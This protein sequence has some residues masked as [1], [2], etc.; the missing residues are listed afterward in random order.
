MTAA[1]EPSGGAPNALD[2]R[3]CGIVPCYN[4]AGK[5]GGVVEGAL[6]H[7]PW[8]VVVD[9]CSTD[10][11]A[12]RAAAAGAS[13]LRHPVNRGKG[14]ALKSGFAEAGRLGYAAGLTLDGDG[15]HDTAEIPRFLAA[16][17]R[18][19]CDI[20][21]GC[22][23]LERAGMPWLRWRTNQFMSWVVSRKAGTKIRDSQVGF[24]LIRVETWRGLKLG[25]DRFD[26]ESEVLIKACRAGARVRE[27]PVRT[28]YGNEV[29]KIRPIRDT[30]RFLSLLARC[31]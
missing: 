21:L 3:V 24:R 16:F 28:I 26:L 15:Q 25:G 5:V 7:L 17:A 12:E 18:G 23:M 27:V 6:R 19:D 13:V 11:T 14:A 31:R 8:V 2:S 20:V 4:E 29:S 9:D 1:A 10:D 30:V 22:R